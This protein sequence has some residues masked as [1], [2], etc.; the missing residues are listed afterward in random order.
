MGSAEAQAKLLGAAAEDWAN[1]QE[2]C[3]KPLSEAMLEATGVAKGTQLLDA[4]CGA[5]ETCALAAELGARVSGLDAAPPLIAIAKKRV[6][7]GDIRVGELEELPYDA[8]F[9]D[10]AIAGNSIQYA[11]DQAVALRE[12]ARVCIGG[13]LVAVGTWGQI[14]DCEMRHVQGAVRDLI[15]DPPKGGGPF[16]LS[17]PGKLEELVKQA[18]LKPLSASEVNCPFVY[19]SIDE[20]WR[21]FRSAGPAQIAIQRIGEAPVEEAAR[22]AAEPFLTKTGSV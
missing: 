8:D 15:P 11:A 21:G 5:G 19:G 10:V 4:G 16:A 7:G 18:D 6:P 13:G 1:I 9:F 17:A 3:L 12:L 2:P 14:A 22:K 20:F